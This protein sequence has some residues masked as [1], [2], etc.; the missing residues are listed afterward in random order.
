MRCLVLGA[1]LLSGCNPASV[2]INEERVEVIVP[3]EQNNF[4]PPQSNGGNERCL[5][6]IDINSASIDELTKIIHINESRAIEI[7]EKRP[8]M[9]VE[10]LTLVTGIYGEILS[11]IKRDPLTCVEVEDEIH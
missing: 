2:T 9:A 1:L 10:S 4:E 3:I 8:F 11:D 5:G 6:K 7:I